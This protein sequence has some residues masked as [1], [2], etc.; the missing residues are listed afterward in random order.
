M[1]DNVHEVEVW[2]LVDEDGCAVASTDVDALAGLYDD[3][4]GEGAEKA[5]RCVKVVLKVPCPSY[6][7][8]T[9]VVP[10]EGEGSLVVG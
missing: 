7:E 1:V 9:G 4:V 3:S 2:V 5:R 10:A 8:M 6:V